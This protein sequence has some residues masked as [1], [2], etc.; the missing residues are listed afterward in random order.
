[1]R[2]TS[3]Y[4]SSIKVLRMLSLSS[5]YLV[6]ASLSI[7]QGN[8]VSTTEVSTSEDHEQVCETTDTAAG[9]IRYT[10]IMSVRT[11]ARD[12]VGVILGSRQSS[13][14]LL[15]A[16]MGVVTGDHN[17]VCDSDFTCMAHQAWYSIW[18]M[19]V[20]FSRFQGI[21]I[22]IQIFFRS[23]FCILILGVF[24]M[25]TDRIRENSYY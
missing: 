24:L 20:C 7:C 15:A 25:S 18:R 13:V 6:S 8:S 2:N 12:W 9:G 19:E 3:E 17:I 21:S 23:E 11:N 22:Y 5:V 14:L 1:M 4:Q 10:W 16:V